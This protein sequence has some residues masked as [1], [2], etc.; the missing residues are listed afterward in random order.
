M[1]RS[2]FYSS[3]TQYVSLS[4]GIHKKI[5]QKKQEISDKLHKYFTKISLFVYWDFVVMFQMP[6]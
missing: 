5:K 4:H 6:F 1:E 3:S 2:V